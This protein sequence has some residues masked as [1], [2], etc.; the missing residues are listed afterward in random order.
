[1]SPGPSAAVR[2]S[3]IPIVSGTLRE[4]HAIYSQR[5]YEPQKFR[6]F[7]TC[8][9]GEALGRLRERGYEVEVYAHPEAPPKSLILAKVPLRDRRPDHHVA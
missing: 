6:V 5:N 2:R 8:D 4:V 1:M 9:I 3:I 7:A